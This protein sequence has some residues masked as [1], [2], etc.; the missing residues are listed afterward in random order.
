MSIYVNMID[1][2][3]SGWGGASRGRSLYSIRCETRAQADAIEKAARE[4]KEMRY[5]TLSDNPPRKRSGDHL[6]VKDFSQVGGPW[7]RYYVG[8]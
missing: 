1:K 2:F 5:V 6:S 7:R 3:M 8:E 4:R